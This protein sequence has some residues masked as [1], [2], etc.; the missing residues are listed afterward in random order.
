[1]KSSDYLWRLVHFMDKS[2]ARRFRLLAQTHNGDKNYLHLYDEVRKAKIAE[3]YDEA[4]IRES[5][6]KDKKV[7]KGSFSVTKNY[8]LDNL[9]KALRF[10]N[11]ESTVEG[12]IQRFY[13]EAQLLYDRGILAKSTKRLQKAK[14]LAKKYQC[15]PLLLDILRLEVNLLLSTMSS[16][17]PE[18]SY[19]NM[20]SLYAEQE[21]AVKSLAQETEYHRLMHQAFVL[22]HTRNTMLGEKG[23][24][25]LQELKKSPALK[26]PERFLSFRS[27]LL[28]HHAWG[29]IYTMENIN[30]NL[31]FSHYQKTL[32]VWEKYPMFKKEYTRSYKVYLFNFLA[33]C[34]S[35]QDY[36]SFGAILQ[37]TQEME[38]RTI[39]ERS[40]DFHNTYHYKLLLLMNSGEAEAAQ[41]LAREVEEKVRLYKKRRYPLQ[42]NKLLSL[43]YNI[44]VLLFASENFESALHW[45]E[46]IRKELRKAEARLDLKYFA[47]ILQLLILF[48]RG[49]DDKLDHKEPYVKRLL[50]ADNMLSEFDDTVLRYI[51]KLSKCR[52]PREERELF[53]GLLQEIQESEAKYRKISGREEVKLWAQ[54]HLEGKKMIDLLREKFQAQ[55]KK[56]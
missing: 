56:E 45:T 24:Q 6:D 1:M 35:Q 10:L 29:L 38:S 42:Q 16:S 13:N 51:R 22:F 34:H 26:K 50:K 25:L 37:K 14:K 44:A 17:Q 49:E 7:P 52:L 21:T 47:R 3:E 18:V 23:A 36:S 12:K 30:P 31:I 43:Y 9:L 27:E 8:L 4:V 46:K 55:R 20:A 33:T 15:F 28:F 41:N 39:F 11:E 32:E 40:R 53:R 19:Q 48:E 54:S 5:L 2:E